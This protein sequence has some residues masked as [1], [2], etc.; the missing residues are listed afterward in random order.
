MSDKNS[1][2]SQHPPEVDCTALS[3]AR[4]VMAAAH[5]LPS[6]RVDGRLLHNQKK[7]SARFHSDDISEPVCLYSKKDLLQT[8]KLQE[9]I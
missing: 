2:V 8:R 3:G 9:I 6:M 5:G 1:T 4:N 7:K